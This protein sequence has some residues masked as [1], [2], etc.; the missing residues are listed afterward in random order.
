MLDIAVIF[1][2]ILFLLQLVLPKTRFNKVGFLFFIASLVLVFGFAGY[3]SW[4][5]YFTWKNSELGKF[6]LP[7]YQNLDYFIFYARTRFFNPYF[8]S[9]FIGFLFFW[10]AKYFNKKYG[11]RF[12]EPIEP[13]LLAT[14]IFIIGHP[15]WLFYLI[16]LLAI[17]LIIHILITNYHLLIAH[18]A[19]PRISLYYFWLPATISTILIG[20]WIETLPW[21]QILKF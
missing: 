20:R 12:F 18:K 10:A 21:W 15:L 5:Q 7:P 19:M 17:F 8:L 6:F 13:Y 2:S 4:Q 14:S 16:F 1:L 9:L 3:Q 11:E